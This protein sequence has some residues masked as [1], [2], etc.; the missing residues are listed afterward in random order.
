MNSRVKTYQAGKT[1]FVVLR[2][3]TSV[4]GF[5]DDACYQ[6]YL[7]RLINCLNTYQ[8]K[9]HAYLLLE[10]QVWLLLTPGTPTGFDSLLRFLNQSYSDYFNTRF[11]RSVKVWSDSVVACL[12]PGNKLVLDCQKFIEREV[13]RINCISHP[14]EY[15]WSSYCANAF[16]RKNGHL[17]AHL[18]YTSFLKGKSDCFTRYR[19]FIAAPYSQAYELF[20]R[21]RL[22]RGVPLL[23]KS[24]RQRLY[25]R[26]D[27]LSTACTGR[28][29]IIAAANPV[30]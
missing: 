30:Y 24:T 11:G 29:G 22:L 25:F 15:R 13:L 5:Y 18:A 10:K 1:Y 20:L 8:V 28:A 14:G 17:S 12:I 27:R 16:S 26:K 9:L 2:E 4:S 3:K 23:R 6:F 21:S 19:E 7:L